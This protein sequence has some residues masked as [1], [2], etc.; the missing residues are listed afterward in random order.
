MRNLFEPRRPKSSK[1]ADTFARVLDSQGL[2][3]GT[4]KIIP[5]YKFYRIV[6]SFVN[7]SHLIAHGTET[8]ATKTQRLNERVDTLA[9]NLIHARDSK[10]SRTYNAMRLNH[11]IANGKHDHR[12]N[13]ELF[14][15]LK[16]QIAEN[17]NT[18][19][20]SRA[21]TSAVNKR[22]A[23]QSLP[24]AEASI[25]SPTQNTELVLQHTRYLPS[26]ALSIPVAEPIPERLNSRIE[27]EQFR[28]NINRERLRRALKQKF[29]GE[30]HAHR[31]R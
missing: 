25:I 4:H 30:N 22:I 3:G 11:E 1:I 14:T 5:T 18:A 27:A 10:D 6:D 15:S 26:E 31:G 20:T 23:N 28:E 21:F 8:S 17:N 16:N 24:I 7:D 19:E 2:E 9:I 12:I 29:N 13:N